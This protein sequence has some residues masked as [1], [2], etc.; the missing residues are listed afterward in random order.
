MHQSKWAEAA[1]LPEESKQTK[2]WPLWQSL[3]QTVCKLVCTLKSAHA[4]ILSVICPQ[5]RSHVP[6]TAPLN[7][8]DDTFFLHT[9][10]SA[11]GLGAVL[12]QEQLDDNYTHGICEPDIVHVR[13]H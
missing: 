11:Q 9:D 4:L 5:L 7:T 10:I 8:P 6:D 1:S 3:R 12:K 13:E 2:D